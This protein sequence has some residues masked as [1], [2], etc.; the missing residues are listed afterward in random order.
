MSK[1]YTWDDLK[2]FTQA[3]IDVN[4]TGAF[5]KTSEWLEFQMDWAKAK[6]AVE[7]P[8]DENAFCNELK[9]HGLSSQCIYSRCS[10]LES[11]LKRPD[12]GRSLNKENKLEHASMQKNVIVFS[13]GLSSLALKKHGIP[14]LLSFLKTLGDDAKKW[15]IM[16]APFSRVGICDDIGSK[17]DIENC[18][19]V[20]GE[21][22]GLSSCDSLGVYYTYQPRLGK[23]DADRN[24]ISN[25]RPPHGLAYQAAAIQAFAL[26]QL[27]SLKL[28]SGVELKIDDAI[29]TLPQNH[30]KSLGTL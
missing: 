11:Y 9:N 23:S 2:Q 20:I 30:K 3:R 18:M 29:A 6:D 4:K 15:A 10:D 22:P 28:T 19:M 26:Y 14:F 12:Y 8:F 27:G 21:R 5:I 7:T 25:I 24:C 13:P 17:L 1:K 16:I